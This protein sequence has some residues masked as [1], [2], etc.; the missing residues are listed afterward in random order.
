MKKVDRKQTLLRLLSDV[1][2]ARNRY[3]MADRSYIDVSA[4]ELTAAE[5]RLNEF[6]RGLKKEAIGA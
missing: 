3:N 6:V 5:R 4:L 2:A 1:E